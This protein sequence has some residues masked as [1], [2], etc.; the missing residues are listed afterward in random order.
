M[1]IRNFKKR[2]T[3]L[4]LNS[5]GN[6]DDLIEVWAQ[7]DGDGEVVAVTSKPKRG[8]PKK[9]DELVIVPPSSSRTVV[10][11]NKKQK[12]DRIDI[13]TLPGNMHSLS[14]SQLRS[15]C[16]ANGLKEFIPPGATKSDLL[17]ILED[18]IFE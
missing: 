3:Q 9:S 1:D 7:K 2:A 14:V 5:D 10:A 11:T 4:G 12:K 15:L 13:S 6:K 8:R 18:N 17:D 16:I